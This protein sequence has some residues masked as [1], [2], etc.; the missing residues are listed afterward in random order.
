[1]HSEASA[2]TRTASYALSE[3][4]FAGQA[5]KQIAV[6]IGYCVSVLA[7]EQTAVFIGC[8][9]SVL[10]CA[11][12][13]SAANSNRFVPYLC[14]AKTLLLKL[15]SRDVSRGGSYRQ[16]CLWH[17]LDDLCYDSSKYQLWSPVSRTVDLGL[18][19]TRLGTM[20]FVVLLLHL[21]ADCVF[22]VHVRL[23]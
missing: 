15:F 23:I 1:V 14:F 17:H 21:F 13:N 4:A 19:H 7:S 9:V 20:G 6:L 22:C 16:H 5:C 18:G 3:A 2:A 12:H 8:C 10:A 11:S